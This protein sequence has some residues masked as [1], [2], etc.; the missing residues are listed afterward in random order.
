MANTSAVD[1]SAPTG[2]QVTAP[3]TDL[4]ADRAIPA[5]GHLNHRARGR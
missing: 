3:S 4:T 5:V 2:R 1:R